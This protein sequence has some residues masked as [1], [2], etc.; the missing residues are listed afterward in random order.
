MVNFDLSTSNTLSSTFIVVR[1]LECG[2]RDKRSSAYVV[3]RPRY[4]CYFITIFGLQLTSLSSFLILILS[5]LLINYS[6]LVT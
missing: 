2:K 4:S 5:F 6:D 3:F 1:I